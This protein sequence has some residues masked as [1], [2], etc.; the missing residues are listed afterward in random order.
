MI[1]ET[2][3]YIKEIL[4]PKLLYMRYNCPRQLLEDMKNYE[5]NY[6]LNNNI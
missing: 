4:K 6:N 2:S 1:F 3:T 5:I